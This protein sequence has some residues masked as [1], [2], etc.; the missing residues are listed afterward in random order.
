MKSK[1]LWLCFVVTMTVAISAPAVRAQGIHWNYAT[2]ITQRF[3][4]APGQHGPA[5]PAPESV[6]YPLYPS[7][8]VRA[9]IAGKAVVEFTVNA[10]GRVENVRAIQGAFPEFDR[11]ATEAVKSWRFLP[12]ARNAPQYPSSVVVRGTFDFELPD[13]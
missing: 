7:E 3:D 11:T 10:E 5:A 4:L 6:P 12:L 2:R 9:G 1:S 8:L 13:L